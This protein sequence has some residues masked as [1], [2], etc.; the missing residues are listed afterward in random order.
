MFRTIALLAFA[1]VIGV[2]LATSSACV[3]G[4]TQGTSTMCGFQLIWPIGMILA[5]PVAVVFG[6][7][8]DFIYGRLGLRRWWQYLI[9]GVLFSLPIWFVMAVSTGLPRWQANG[10]FV[11]FLDAIN[12]IGVGVIASLVYW[13]LKTSDGPGE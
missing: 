3:I 8:A 13:W 1:A 9:G 10:F 6:L 5:I 12:L 11:A 2:I 7:P 4:L